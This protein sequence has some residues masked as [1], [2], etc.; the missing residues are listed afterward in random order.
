MTPDLSPA[1][2]LADDAVQF[3]DRRLAEIGK[4]RPARIL[5]F[6]SG[7][8]TLWFAKRGA[9]VSV[10]N[11]PEWFAIV[12]SALRAHGLTADLRLH[13]VPLHPVC[14]A[15]E[16]D[17][18]DLVL[19]DQEDFADGHHRVACVEAARRLVSPG[20]AMMLDN[21]DRPKFARAF[22]IMKDWPCDTA[23]QPVAKPGYNQ[24]SATSWWHRQP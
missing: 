23:T 21:S 4:T 11:D 17:A 16:A 22:E 8:S 15:F 20:G 12:Q 9:L 3:L 6:G 18:F 19:V 1:C 10:E 24:G 14:N 5:E 7:G 2:R 13:P